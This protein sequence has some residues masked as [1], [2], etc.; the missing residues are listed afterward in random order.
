[1]YILK[2]VLMSI[3]FVSSSLFSQGCWDI[4]DD[5]DFANSELNNELIFSFKNVDDCQPIENLNI[6]FFGQ[7][8][9]TN[10]KGEI[11]L[12]APPDNLDL[13][14]ILVAKKNGY[15]TLKQKVN[16]MIGTFNTQ[17]FL[18]VKDLP[19]EQAKFILSWGEKPSDLDLHLRSEDFHVSF[20]K[21][22]GDTRQA[23]LDRDSMNGY[24]PETIT[25]KKLNNYKKY[26]VFVHQY[27]SQGNI[28]NSVNLSIYTNGK[29]DKNVQFPNNIMKKCI[30]VATI[31]NNKVAYDIKPAK[32]KK[33]N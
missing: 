20:R 13:S 17:K 18:L 21:K 32:L 7:N 6:S 3:I 19:I 24:G 27:S 29:L 22:S 9:T 10:E 4:K 26:K 8:F 23:Y 30:K 15:L 1:M 5:A 31:Y 12:P 25:L 33:C 16:A 28:S 2:K 11:V 14:D